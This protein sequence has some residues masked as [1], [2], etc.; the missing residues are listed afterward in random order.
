MRQKA[1]PF[2][3]KNAL[4]IDY[5]DVRLVRKFVSSYGKILPRRRTGLCAKHQRQVTNEIKKT[6]H[7][8]LISFVPQ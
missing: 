2:H 6:R 5:K 3:G 4:I 7:M 1:C 8:A